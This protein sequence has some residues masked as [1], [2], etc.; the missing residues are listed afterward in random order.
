MITA[1]TLESSCKDKLSEIIHA[2]GLA[3]CLVHGRHAD[4]IQQI[5]AKYVHCARIV[6]CALG[7]S[8]GQNRPKSLHSHGESD[9]KQVDGQNV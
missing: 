4:S 8:I 5:L 7:H 9:S 2:E 1:L 6:P 3:L